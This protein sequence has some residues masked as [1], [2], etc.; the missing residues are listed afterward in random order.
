MITY[1]NKNKIMSETEVKTEY[2]NCKFVLIKAFEKNQIM[3]GELKAISTNIS[4]QN[5]L[6][7]YGHSFDDLGMVFF[8]GNYNIETICQGMIKFGENT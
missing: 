7:T 8:G 2:P 4:D 6:F 3:Y 5:D 1:I